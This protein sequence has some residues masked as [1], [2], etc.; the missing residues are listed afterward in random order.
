MSDGILDSLNFADFQICIGCI[1]GK[2]INIRRLGANRSSNVL[3]LI[4]TD[5][6]GPFPT[7]SWNGQQYFV[8]FIDDYSRYAYLFLIYKKILSFGRI[9]II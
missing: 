7:P 3:E 1:K 2:Q 5:I 6:C 8:S 4:H 9:Q